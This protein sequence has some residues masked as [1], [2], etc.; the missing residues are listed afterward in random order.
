MVGNNESENF[1]ETRD[2][3][4][5]EEEED[6]E[7][8]PE[9]SEELKMDL[10]HRNQSRNYYEAVRNPEQFRSDGLLVEELFEERNKFFE[11]LEERMGKG[12]DLASLG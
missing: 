4:L 5:N 1:G 2:Y 7:E 12:E 10:V 11:P 6:E 9:V 8:E 3:E